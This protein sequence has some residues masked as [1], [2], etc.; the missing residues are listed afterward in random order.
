MG[1]QFFPS[2]LLCLGRRRRATKRAPRTR[3]KRAEYRRFGW[4]LWD[5]SR[6]WAHLSQSNRLFLLPVSDQNETLCLDHRRDYAL[7]LISIQPERYRPP[8]PPGRDGI[9]IPV[10]ARREPVGPGQ[11]LPRSAPVGP[12]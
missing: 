3:T 5:S 4:R 1:Q 7:F 10:S 2:L 11:A 12:P 8:G 9:R 6:V